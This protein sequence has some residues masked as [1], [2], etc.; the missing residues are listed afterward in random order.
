MA[1]RK[2]IPEIWNR[3]RDEGFQLKISPIKLI[4]VVMSAPI[5]LNWWEGTVRKGK[6]KHDS[7]R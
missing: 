6:R 7:G 4:R 3:D 5:K 2:E 1:W